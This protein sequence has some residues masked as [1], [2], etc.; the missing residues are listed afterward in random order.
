MER[1]RVNNLSRARCAAF[2]SQLPPGCAW[3]FG[4]SYPAVL[5]YRLVSTSD[6]CAS[7]PA[8]ATRH[9]YF[10]EGAGSP[11]QRCSCLW[12]WWRLPAAG[13]R[14]A[15]HK[16][17]MP[18]FSPSLSVHIRLGEEGAQL[19]VHLLPPAAHSSVPIIIQL[20]QRVGKNR[21]PDACTRA[22]QH[23]NACVHTCETDLSCCAQ[24]EQSRSLWILS[25][26]TYRSVPCSSCGPSA[27]SLS[28]Q[29][30]KVGTAS[31][32][33]TALQGA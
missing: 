26:S 25:C 14:A 32:R 29:S 12:I 23:T 30:S 15:A 10:R 6:C 22:S 8:P 28:A 20:M 5:G 2:G 19:L 1:G 21:P 3:K 4:F 7:N 11:S 33:C 31:L 18:C 17:G 27:A 13:V 9:Q 24:C 16:G